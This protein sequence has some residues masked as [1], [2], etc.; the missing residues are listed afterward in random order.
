MRTGI[1]VESLVA[2]PFRGRH[3]LEYAVTSPFKSPG[4]SSPSGTES[5]RPRLRKRR[6]VK[7]TLR[8]RLLS[9]VISTVA[10]F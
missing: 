3:Y 10:I 5:W 1:V 4:G 9:T 7:Q 8:C 6:Y 2:A